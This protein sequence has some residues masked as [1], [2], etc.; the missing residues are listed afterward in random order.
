[1]GY[2]LQTNSLRL[3]KFTTSDSK[4]IL[5]LLNSPGWLEFIGDKNIN[6]VLDAI[7]YI[8]NV[9]LKSYIENGY[10][11]SM[12]ELKETGTPLGMCGIINRDSLEYPDIGFAYLP[13]FAGFGYAYEICF[14]REKLLLYSN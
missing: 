6:T 4:F 10:G 5:Q 14:N 3:R 12:V 1:M 9:L 8:E 7:T 11:L 2:T 13:E